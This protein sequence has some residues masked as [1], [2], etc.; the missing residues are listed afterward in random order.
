MALT[1]LDDPGLNGYYT[2]RYSGEE[3]DKL[4]SGLPP[5]GAADKSVQ[6]I[7]ETVTVPYR[8]AQVAAAELQ[9]YLDAMPRLLTDYLVLEVTGTLEAEVHAANFYG[10]GS[11]FLG[12]KNLVVKN[13]MHFERFCA[14]M[15]GI[16]SIR[17][18]E[19]AGAEPISML[20]LTG[21]GSIAIVQN[22]QFVGLG[23]SGSASAIHVDGPVFTQIYAVS[24]SGCVTA[25]FASGGAT[26]CVDMGNLSSAAYSGNQQGIIVYGG[27]TAYLMPGVPDLLGGTT[28]GKVAG[29]IVKSDGT[30]L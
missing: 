1:N 8:V 24:V 22:C 5:G 13:K 6:D 3:V 2:H 14:A 30:L 12:G 23:S 28:N 17:F 16:Q 15:L 7:V 11:L 21:S 29:L 4:L 25:L 26:A 19:P 20:H 9:G 27:G 18:E 10:P